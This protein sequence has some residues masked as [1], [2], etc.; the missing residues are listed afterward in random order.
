MKKTIF[1]IVL[2]AVAIGVY[3][4]YQ[5][6][7]NKS[8]KLKGHIENLS[9]GRNENYKLTYAQISLS[10]YP[11]HHEVELKDPCISFL[12]S[13]EDLNLHVLEA[14]LKGDM[15]LS[16][17]PFNKKR[18]LF[19]KTDGDLQLT[20]PN[21]NQ[22]EEGPVHVKG[23]FSQT[24]SFEPDFEYS[25]IHDMKYLLENIVVAELKA[26]NIDI[27]LA[28]TS[29]DPIKDLS[30]TLSYSR[31]PFDKKS[32]K[33]L[34]SI[35]YE[36]LLGAPLQSSSDSSLSQYLGNLDETLL[37]FNKKSG[38]NRGKYD[39][40]MFIPNWADFM[41]VLHKVNN[42]DFSPNDL[43]NF[44]IDLDS[45]IKNNFY[46]GKNRVDIHWEKDSE[47]EYTFSLKSIGSQDLTREGASEL[48]QLLNGVT[49]EIFKITLNENENAGEKE[50]IER[51][52]S[53]NFNDV[54]EG[55]PTHLD[56]D[57]DID[58]KKYVEDNKELVN[59]EIHPF[60]IQTDKGGISLYTN[61]H[62]LS[63]FEA[64]ISFDSFVRLVDGLLTRYNRIV[65]KL[66]PIEKFPKVSEKER[67]YLLKIFQKYSDQPDGMPRTVKFTIKETEDGMFIGKDQNIYGLAGE[68]AFFVQ[69]LK[70]KTLENSKNER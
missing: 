53:S 17:D 26:R 32:Q 35:D 48:E 45:S 49:K 18:S 22:E 42:L 57:I 65:E 38:V 68:L 29:E 27:S 9:N 44:S 20:I 24:Y 55:I 13:D 36:M 28:K 54:Y 64:T 8:N 67:D 6:W 5:W 70:D 58:I 30:A 37:N 31:K 23:Q 46:T 39:V 56:L 52:A 11:F 14:C 2:L 7:Q 51:V 1:A 33:I 59:A 69:H 25:K 60:S 40:T 4:H 41:H 61:Y 50:K 34:F 12:K 15:Q 19:I 63:P 3:G 62:S 16:Y 47:Q 10:G 66:E 21:R 43:P